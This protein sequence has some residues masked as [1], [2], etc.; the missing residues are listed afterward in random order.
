MFSYVSM[1]FHDVQARDND[2]R[3]WR[4][5]GARARLGD[6]AALVPSAVVQSAVQYKYMQTCNLSQLFPHL[7]TSCA[8]CCAGEHKPQFDFCRISNDY[9][10]SAPVVSV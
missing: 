10:G 8:T 6:R 3:D 2:N 9:I 7:F 1:C 4:Q 5:K